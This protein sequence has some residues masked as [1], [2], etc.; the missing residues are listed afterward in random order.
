MGK[1]AAFEDA[2]ADFSVAYADQNERNHAAL[3]DAIRT[4]GESRRAWVNRLGSQMAGTRL[5]SNR[6]SSPGSSLKLWMVASGRI[7]SACARLAGVSARRV[8][9]ME[10]NPAF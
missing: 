10:N 5:P 2:L 4:G 1:N 7:V 9:Q 3:M 6:F 8:S